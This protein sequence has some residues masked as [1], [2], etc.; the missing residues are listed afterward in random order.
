M[1]LMRL[2]NIF[3]KKNNMTQ[4]SPTKGALEQHRKRAT[5]QGVYVWCQLLPTP[6]LPHQQAGDGPRMRMVCMNLTTN[7]PDA[8]KACYELISCKCK[9]GCVRN[10]KCKKKTALEC[11]VLCEC[12]G[13]CFQT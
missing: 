6:A 12:E 3:T 8:S 10:C 11:T 9:K 13:Q 4:I 2:E 1:T 7:L 5:Y